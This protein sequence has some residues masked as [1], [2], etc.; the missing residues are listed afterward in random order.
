MLQIKNLTITHRKDLRLILE[1]FHLT[2]NPGDRAAII[3]EEG[4]GKS[5]LIKWIYE[6]NMTEAYTE[7]TGERI[8]T[9]ERLGYLPQEFPDTERCK[10]VYEYFS[11]SD[12][13]YNKT[14][15]ELSAM[16]RQFCVEEGFFYSDQK[17]G[18]L[19]G[20]EKMKAELMR[21]FMEE[22]TVLLLDEPSNDM[23]IDTLKLLEEVILSWKGIVLYISHDETLIENT[24]NVIIHIEQIARKTK[25]R[26]TIAR[27]PYRQYVEQRIQSFDK[28]KRE[29]VNERS[30]KKKRDEKYRRVMQSVE[31]A[32]NVITRQNPAAGRLLKKKMHAV[33]SMEKRFQ[34]KDENMT[35]MP[36]MENAIYFK[37]GDK[38]SEIP[39]GKMV[40]EYS[41]D[42]LWTPDGRR[43]L[44]QDIFLRMQ[45]A[46]K[47]CI[48]GS[49]GSG[50]TTLLKK[51]AEE[52][53]Q[54]KDIR[55][56]YMPQNYE[57]ILG[58]EK[59]PVDFL[60]TTGYQEDRTKIRTYLGSLKYTASEMERPIRELSGGQKAK[61]LLLKLSLSK[62]NVLILDEPTRNFSPLSG[63]VIRQ[64]IKEFSGAVI[65]ISHDRKYIDEV[66][67]KVYRLSEQGLV[68][69]REIS[70]GNF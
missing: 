61:V 58:L 20:G 6:P 45:G 65:S 57:E 8:C 25:C 51:I 68:L 33:K 15:K 5:T 43:I 7:C 37:L 67:D 63:P 35:E 22:P 19:S 69:E 2:L 28:Q 23:D 9:K 32:Q 30:E 50:K 4:N 53:L 17:M 24:A 41:L 13:F 36:E 64:M 42:R 62:A 12:F 55:A 31:H 40:I 14:P 48:I 29:A 49:N 18:S 16:A 39:A 56:E 60:D 21:I 26:Y 52:L 70:H 34:R 47:I 44:A 59:T 54:R 3:G 46:E 11:Q 66:C 27:V 38:N 10:T 1:D